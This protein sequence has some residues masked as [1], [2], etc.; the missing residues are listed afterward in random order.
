MASQLRNAVLHSLAIAAA[1]GWAGT[2]VAAE[3]S[4]RVIDGATGRPLPGAIVRIEGAAGRVVADRSGRFRLR[5]LP[6]SDVALIVS[7]I[8][9]E[10][11]RL[12]VGPTAADEVRSIALSA[13]STTEELIVTGFRAAQ[14]NALQAKRIADVIKDQ[15]TA[16]D[17]GKLPDQ[18]AAEALQR[19]PGVSITID[20]GEGRYVTV[21]GVDPSYNNVT[22]DG[23]IIGVPEGD[24]RRIALDTIPSDLLSKLEVVKT[25]TPDM[26]GNAIGGAVNI[27][28]PSAFDTAEGSF[29]K[30]EAEY[31]YYDLNGES[32][33]GAALSWGSTFGGDD[34]F[35][36]V[37]SGSYSFREYASENVQ[38]NIWE[39]EGDYFIPEEL[40]LRDYSLERERSGIVAN[41]EWRPSED[42]QLYF[43]NLFNRFEDTEERLQ[44]IYDYRNGDLID[45]TATSGTF[46]IDDEGDGPEGERLVKYRTEKQTIQTSTLGG[47]FEFGAWTLGAALTYGEAEQDTPFDNE[48]SFE[49]DEPLPMTYDT[50][51]FF[52]TVDGGPAFHEASGYEFNELERARQIVDEE[53]NVAQLDL[54]RDLSFGSNAGYVK[55]GAKY[56]S[57]DKTSDQDADVFDGFDGDLTLD[58]V[59]RP[60]RRDFYS[61]E[62]RYE[63][64]PIVDYGAAEAVFRDSNA[65]FER[66]DGDSFE[67]SREADYRVQEDVLAGYV[68]AGADVGAWSFVGGV[69]VEETDADFRAYELIFED[70]DVIEEDF[71]RTGGRKY[72]NWLPG[73][74]FTYEAGRDLLVRGAWTNTIG[75]PSYE[76]IVPFRIFE[77]DPDGDA[78]FEGSVEQGNPD[79]D[80]LES[81]N[82]D[83]SVE[84]YLDT[85]GI[86]AVALFYKDIDNPIYTQVT[87]LEDVEF[88]G[89]F[90]TELEVS[91]PLNAD[92]GELRGIEFNYQN[93]FRGLPAPFNGFGVALN[94]TYVDSEANV[95]GREDDV[96]FFLQSEHLGNLALFYEKHG[97]EARIAL[98]YRS[99]YLEELGESPETDLWIDS[100]EQLDFKASYDFTENV[101][102]FVEWL[103][104]T[105]EPLRYLSGSSSRLAE[106]EIYSWNAMVGVQVSF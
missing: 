51:S 42:V 86:L 75:R 25:V 26:D 57:R 62:R 64:G 1:S 73:L 53:L 4:G 10:D 77:I 72:T 14:A 46:I 34:Q 106:N 79:L 6:D 105:D 9:Y 16:N 47:D 37:L 11:V 23:Q 2:A 84:W 13:T 102:G 12:V 93:Q 45:Q 17:V 71:V 27:V 97:F 48:W 29:F 38:G 50:S 33:Y 8:G 68:M 80:P 52:F 69:R 7:S 74:Q 24:S 85:G 22:I 104:I 35:G 81:M 28:T 55:F 5:D 54:Q 15:I 91:Q 60:G 76:T 99:R 82:F 95:F 67:V 100:R 20:Q 89:R 66:S 3:V 36:I 90:F 56:V 21:R 101:T 70:G 43:R 87:Q 19:V 30:A 49:I 78:A 61:S 41:F 92:S 94:Y 31:G 98:A 58:Q 39:E 44:T 103:N 40:V 83:A 18:N 32:P 88:E 65:L 59:S 63:F 96:P